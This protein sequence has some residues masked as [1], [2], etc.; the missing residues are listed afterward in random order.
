MGIAMQKR[1]N[2]L[3]SDW[4]EMGIEKPFE[5]RIGI[6][7][8]YCTVGNFGSEDRMDYTIIGA[9]VN[10]ASRLEYESEA[11]GILL[12]HETYSLVKDWVMADHTQTIDVK[13]FSRPVKTYRVK[14][15]YK[16]LEAEGQVA[17]HHGRGIELM[18]DQ[19]AMDDESKKRAAEA[20]EKALEQ[21]KT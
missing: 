8:G 11:G 14:G 4:R 9:E 17:H 21:L 16:D 10:L 7:T 1:M 19:S 13:G 3:R 2:E 5:I 6:N 15:L 12:A 20:L 18:I